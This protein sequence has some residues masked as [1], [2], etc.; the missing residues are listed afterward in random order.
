MVKSLGGNSI[1]MN[2]FDWVELGESDQVHGA[3]LRDE[4]QMMK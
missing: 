4:Q 1:T 2:E 3:P